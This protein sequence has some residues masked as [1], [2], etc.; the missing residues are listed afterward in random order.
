M[1]QG[2]KI[3]GCYVVVFLCIQTRNLYSISYGSCSSMLCSDIS[4]CNEHLI[5][6]T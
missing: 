6:A 3:V 2:S 5:T 4:L 1:K